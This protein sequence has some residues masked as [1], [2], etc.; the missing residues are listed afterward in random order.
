MKVEKIAGHTVKLYDGIEEL[1]I[2]RYHVFNRYLLYDMGIGSDYEAI[3]THIVRIAKLIEE[4]K[5]KAV[6]ELENFRTSLYFLLSGV[7]PKNMA[8]AALVAEIDGKPREDLSDDGIKET[9]RYFE[10]ARHG[11]LEQLFGAVKKKIGEELRTYFPEIFSDVREKD[12][13][14]RMVRRTRLILD[15]IVSRTDRRDDIKRIDTFILLSTPPRE[16]STPKG[17]D[18]AF[19]KS[20]SDMCLVISEKFHTPAE[21][22]SVLKFYRALHIMKHE[23]KEARKGLKKR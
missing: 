18:V 10:S 11:W 2:S 16:F 22:M 8:F 3:D 15:G 14:T 9:L 5:T 19:D 23:A 6:T 13:L 1:P 17:A 4:D 12:T 7:S 20:Y 21:N